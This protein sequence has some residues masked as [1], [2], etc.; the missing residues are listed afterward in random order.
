MLN[1]FYVAALGMQA[2]KS[3]LDVVSN[4]LS[5]ANTA[6]YKRERVDF[7][8]M[9][10]RQVQGAAPNANANANAS[11][12]L[13]TLHR[14]LTQGEL[15]TS[16]SVLD[17]AINGQGLIEIELP[18]ERAAFVRGGS[19]RLNAD[20]FLT[21]AAGYPLRSDVRVPPNASDLAI[22]AKGIVS[23]RL[24]NEQQRTELGRLQLVHFAQLDRLDYQGNGIFTAPEGVD[25]ALK[26]NPQEDGL[27][28][29][30]A[31]K[32]EMSN[33]KLVDEMVALMMSQRVYE[34]NAKVAQAADEIMS[35]TNGLRRG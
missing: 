29:I 12:Q 31:G 26:G 7:S 4:N 22:D 34:L 6:G 9:L 28:A 33:V 24:G 16:D 1:S 30:A 35:M 18:G 17:I 25:V 11:T 5:N 14:D 2:Q 20:G 27:G 8:A 13:S 32:L 19:M 3:Q 10:D 15:R 23:A 21:T